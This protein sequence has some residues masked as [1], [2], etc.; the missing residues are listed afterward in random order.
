MTPTPSARSKRRVPVLRALGEAVIAASPLLVALAVV[1]YYMND[2]AHQGR[3]ALTF[4]VWVILPMYFLGAP[5]S[6]FLAPHVD[7]VIMAISF[8]GAIVLN[9]T[10]LLLFGVKRWLLTGF[11]V[12][13]AI[14]MSYC[15][16]VLR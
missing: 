3:F 13:I 16:F 6:L 5:W 10:I 1:L 12:V 14:G 4:A 15:F 9:S 7:H 8:A 11:F 2:P